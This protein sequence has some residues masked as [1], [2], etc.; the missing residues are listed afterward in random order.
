MSP[1]ASADA[2]AERD[3]SP[4]VY[5]WSDLPPWLAPLVRERVSSRHAWPHALLLSG[6]QGI[7]KRAAALH[8]AR[9]LLCETPQPDGMACASCASCH[10]VKAGQHPDLRVLEPW[11]VDDDGEVKQVEDITVDRVRELRAFLAVSSHRGGGKVAVI[12]PAERM[13]VAAANALL[14]TLEEPPPDSYLLLVAHQ[15]GRLL[16]TIV[17]RCRRMPVPL[18][19][20]AEA[21][22]WL[23]EQGVATP[24]VVLAQAGGAPLAALLRA[25]PSLQSERRAW[26][27]A[28][29]D[30]ATLSAPQL[31][32]RIDVG[33][34][35]E[36][37]AR[38]A[39]ALD[40][41]VAWS[42]DLATA[43]AG[44]PV[45]RNPD[46]AGPLAALAPRVAR[47][48]LSRYHRA[49]LQRRRLLN[50]PLTPRLAAEAM[51]LDYQALFN[52][53]R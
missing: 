16:P 12:V 40:W 23:G 18:P 1:R 50:H 6:A 51:L 44:A 15:P 38:L 37:R 52:D 32:A 48:S 30:P 5:A 42:T 28:L 24:E 19:A 33:V 25:E 7:G 46:F 27:T 39:L 22:A 45:Q 17:S 29:A 3:P 53:G 41:L 13:N 35:E 36:R 31:S 9:A 47:I 34:R 49:L 43:A 2:V 4:P 26:L 8:M 21:I 20:R 11:V 10:Y 14:K